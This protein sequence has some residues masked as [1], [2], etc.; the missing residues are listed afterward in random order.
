MPFAGRSNRFWAAAVRAGLVAAERDPWAALRSGIGF[1][2]LV[3][4]PTARAVTL[5]RRELRAGLERVDRRARRLEPAAVCVAGVGA[6]R[7]LLGA[8]GPGPSPRPVGE[9][10]TWAM[11][12]PSGAN[13][14]ATLPAIA[15]HLRAAVALG[16]GA[17]SA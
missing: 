17:L 10:P 9:R 1:C 11:P 8:P 14:A 3:K 4:R 13:P 2:D 6:G 15:E 5:T 16:G 12:N 7:T